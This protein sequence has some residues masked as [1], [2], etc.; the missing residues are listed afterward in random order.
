MRKGDS[1]P[2]GFL[3]LFEEAGDHH[4]VLAGDTIYIANL[5]RP[6]LFRHRGR[7]LQ[8]LG[9]WIHVFGPSLALRLS[10]RN[11]VLNV[12]FSVRVLVV[13]RIHADILLVE[14]MSEQMPLQ[15]HEEHVGV[16]RDEFPILF[17]DLEDGRIESLLVHEFRGI[18]AQGDAFILYR[19]LRH[20]ACGKSNACQNDQRDHGC[21]SHRFPLS[22]SASS[23]S[24]FIRSTLAVKSSR[25]VRSPPPDQSTDEGFRP[26]TDTLANRYTSRWEEEDRERHRASPTAGMVVRSSRGEIIDAER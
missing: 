22:F 1:N 24:H 6:L 14:R 25:P 2:Y 15:V 12:K 4:E 21:L 17:I 10:N 7:L 11:V 9:G 16:L 20:H 26:H 13:L 18:L 19:T 8:L 23:V 5:F 3:C